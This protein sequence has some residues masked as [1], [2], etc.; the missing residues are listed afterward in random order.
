MISSPNERTKPGNGGILTTE[1]LTRRKAATQ[2]SE[3]RNL[4]G[5]WLFLWM[6]LKKRIKGD[7]TEVCIK[8]API[9][10]RCQLLIINAKV[11]SKLMIT[12]G[13]AAIKRGRALPFLWVA[14]PVKPAM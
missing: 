7:T 9:P 2:R 13:N 6:V 3:G 5:R 8:V 14:L 11:M 12:D 1:G 10:Q 4:K